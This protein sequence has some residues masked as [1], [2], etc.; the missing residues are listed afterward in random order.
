MAE[1]ECDRRRN[2][3]Q[4]RI[5]DARA[6]MAAGGKKYRAGIG[7]LLETISEQFEASHAHQPA[8]RLRSYDRLEKDVDDLHARLDGMPPV[9]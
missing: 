3:L 5:D 8:E 4:A 1:E 7:Q 6:R 9:R 2:D